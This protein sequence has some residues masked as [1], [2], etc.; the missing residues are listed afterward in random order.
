ML[1]RSRTGRQHLLQQHL[2]LVDAAAIAPQPFRQRVEQIQFHT[3][4]PQILTPIWERMIMC[5]VLSGEL[6][7]DADVMSV[8]WYPPALPWVDPA[9]DA[10]AEATLIASG[11]K[12]RRQ[13]VAERGYDI[14][15]LDSEIA[16]DRKR[17]ADLG[18][19]FA[20]IPKVEPSNA[21]A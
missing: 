4:I 2:L 15:T 6:E 21:G 10:D 19:T 17:E 5:A 8:E 18:L 7:F 20:P 13:A 9:K 1:F 12:S 11:L 14:E 16:A 3:L